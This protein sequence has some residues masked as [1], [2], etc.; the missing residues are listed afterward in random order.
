[1]Q[2]SHFFLTMALK[3]LFE[4]KPSY[5]TLIFWK[6]QTEKATLPRRALQL[7]P[8]TECFH[9]SLYKVKTYTFTRNNTSVKTVIKT[10]NLTAIFFQVNTQTVILYR[11]ADIFIIL[12][13]FYFDN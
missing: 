11:H 7:N 2:L 5:G 13:S 4:I 6:V 3:C 9:L 8:P 1:M 10:E 12:A